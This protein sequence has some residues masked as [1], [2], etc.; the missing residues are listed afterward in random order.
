MVVRLK[1]SFYICTVKSSER[2][3]VAAA[4]QR[5]LCPLLVVNYKRKEWGNSNVP[6]G[7][8]QNTLTAPTALSLLSNLNVLS[9]E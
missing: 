2:H 6:V 3:E 9:Y 5:F 4:K 7:L 8:A 1:N